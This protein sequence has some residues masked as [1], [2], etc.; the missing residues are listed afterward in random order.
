MNEIY[1]GRWKLIRRENRTYFFENIYNHEVITVSYKTYK[2][3]RDGITTVSRVIR[4]KMGY[5]RSKK[6]I[7]NQ[8]PRGNYGKW[9]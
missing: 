6:F 4:S 7:P 5:N 1:D 8:K 9:N 2:K 3:I